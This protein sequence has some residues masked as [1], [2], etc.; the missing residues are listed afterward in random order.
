MV[1][2]ENCINEVFKTYLIV[3]GNPRFSDLNVM[4]AYRSLLGVKM[5]RGEISIERGVLMVAEK[6][7]QLDAAANERRIQAENAASSREQM[8]L[9][10]LPRSSAS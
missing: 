3:P 2:R 1:T 10:P 8:T 4:N 6:G 9:L 7:A 5:D